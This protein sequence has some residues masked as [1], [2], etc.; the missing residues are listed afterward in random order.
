MSIG[1]LLQHYNDELKHIDQTL[2]TPLTKKDFTLDPSFVARFEQPVDQDDDHSLEDLQQKYDTINKEIASLRALTTSNPRLEEINSLLDKQKGISDLLDFQQLC[3]LLKQGSGGASTRDL[4]NRLSQQMNDY[5]LLLMPSAYQINNVYILMEFNSLATKNGFVF[6]NYSQMLNEWLNVVDE[7]FEHGVG[8]KLK[9]EEGDEYV[10]LEKCKNDEVLQSCNDL[11]A[12]V[13]NVGINANELAEKI[14]S[15]VSTYIRA[16]VKKI[17]SDLDAVILLKHLAGRA[18]IPGISPST[19]DSD[20]Q[21]IYDDAAVT[22]YIDRIKLVLGSDLEK[23]QDWEV[24]EPKEN[25]PKEEEDNWDDGWDESWDD[26]EP[27]EEKEKKQVVK[28]SSGIG[29]VGS[30]LKEYKSDLGEHSNV[31]VTAVIALAVGKY[32]PV[33]ESFLVYNDFCYLTNETGI[34]TFQ[35]WVLHEFNESVIGYYKTIKRVVRDLLE[36]TDYSMDEFEDKVYNYTGELYKLFNGL[37]QL[38][39]TNGEK[40]RGLVVNLAECVNLSLIKAVIMLPDIGEAQSGKISQVIDELKNV[41]KPF[42]M[43]INEPTRNLPSYN[44]LDNIDFLVLHS[45]AEIM[46]RFND[47]KFHDVETS[48]LCKMLQN[49]FEESEKRDMYINEIV[50]IR[51]I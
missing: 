23:L 25:E 40:F 3:V 8:L 20:L 39:E 44:K 22:D 26:D 38:K 43:E 29:K 31:V 24:S 48:E 4:N 2:S 19:V 27:E 37:S 15:H 14:A 18:P 7:I 10:E 1:S 33:G 42:L 36:L 45:L 30:I 41:T 28:I 6:E 11:M 49:L 47:G 21:K 32:P 46:E 16:N 17:A 34:D 9:G 13:D 35:N 51:N 5:L 50:D 12:F